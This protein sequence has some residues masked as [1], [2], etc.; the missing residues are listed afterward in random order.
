MQHSRYTGKG[1]KSA[2]SPAKGDGMEPQKRAVRVAADDCPKCLG[3]DTYATM[4]S[5]THDDTGTYY[6]SVEV[7]YRCRDVACANSWLTTWGMEYVA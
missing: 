5:F 1:T 3:S 7:S 2:H 4:A 6:S